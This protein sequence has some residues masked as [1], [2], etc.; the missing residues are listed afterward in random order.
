MGVWVCVTR[1]RGDGWVG[2]H[3]CL[4]GC[5]CACAEEGVESLITYTC[6]C[7]YVCVCVCV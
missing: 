5:V 7:V 3:L 6:G 4:G 2:E 1:G